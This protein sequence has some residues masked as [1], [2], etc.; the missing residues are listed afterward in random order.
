MTQINREHKD[1]VFRLIFADES[2]KKNALSLYNA[3]NHSSYQNEE[4]LEL[5][6]IKEAIYITMKNDLSFIIA[7]TMNLYEQQSTHNPNM[8]LRGFIYYGS[9]YIKY[10]DENDLS[11]HVSTIVKIPTPNYI[12]FYNGI[13]KR[14]AMEKLRLS[15]AFQVPDD[16]GEFEWTATVINLNHKDNK[17]LLQR[18]KPL[19]DYTTL[20][21]KI[22]TYQ[23]TMSVTEAVNR[24][25]DEC[26]AE[27][28][29]AD[30]L[31]A[32]RAEVLDLY[33]AEVNEE[34]LRKNLKAEGYH[35]G[36][37]AGVPIGKQKL[38]TEQITKKIKVGK[39][40]EQIAE[41]VELSVEEIQNL[42]ETIQN[43]LLLQA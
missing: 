10:L 1:R 42:Y 26:I 3:L 21:S 24:A 36:F 43:E 6:T 34:V 39:P 41:E 38:L 9:L 15:S 19:S 14:P 2:H 16:R 5:T 25:V 32:R 40:L 20:I 29:L 33:L 22:Q 30:F 31:K 13:T 12:V 18:C 28:V 7:D 8:P 23:Q 35:E 17:D 4:E 11:P 37:D 27:D